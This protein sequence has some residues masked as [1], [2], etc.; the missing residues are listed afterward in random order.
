MRRDTTPGRLATDPP[1]STCRGRS[2]RHRRSTD[3]VARPTPAGT[4][5]VRSSDNTSA[6]CSAR[7]CRGHAAGDRAVWRAN[8]A[9]CARSWEFTG[10]LRT[11]LR[12]R[13]DIVVCAEKCIQKLLKLVEICRHCY[14]TNEAKRTLARV[15][16]HSRRGQRCAA[17]V[18]TRPRRCC[19]PRPGLRALL[20]GAFR[21]EH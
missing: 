1:R 6:T 17:N 4:P 5:S 15:D 3:R 20:K 8:D 7:T 16:R 19:Q 11:Y 18:T 21:W 9:D 13:P 12:P 10:C 14:R 2:S